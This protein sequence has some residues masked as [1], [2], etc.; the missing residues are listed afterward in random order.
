MFKNQA[1]LQGFLHVRRGKHENEGPKV[2]RTCGALYMLTSKVA[3][4]HNGVYFFD[5]STSKSALNVVCF[6][7]LNFE[8]CF[9]PQRRTLFR[10]LNFQKCSERGVF[11]TF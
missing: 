8:M 3:S 2:A 10:H 6:V 9:A 1:I 5:I 7:H 4:R 11:C